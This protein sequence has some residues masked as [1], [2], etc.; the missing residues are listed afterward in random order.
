MKKRPSEEKDIAPYIE[1]GVCRI[2]K[3]FG[4]PSIPYLNPALVG[5]EGKSAWAGEETDAAPVVRKTVWDRKGSNL[6][7]CGTRSEPYFPDGN[8]FRTSSYELQGFSVSPDVVWEQNLTAVERM[9]MHVYAGGNVTD[10]EVGGNA[11][12][13][14]DAEIAV[15]DSNHL[16]IR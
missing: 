9:G 2:Q 3:A 12:I 6:C 4:V 7:R 11:V 16:S 10:G 13:V 5:E 1:I 15:K 14:I 8:G